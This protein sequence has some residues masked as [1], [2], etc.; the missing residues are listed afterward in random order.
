MN[1]RQ[2]RLEA[3]YAQLRQRFDGDPYLHIQ[4]LGPAP[5]ERYRITF[6]VPSLRLDASNQPVRVPVTVVDLTLPI[7]YPR[8]KPFAATIGTVFHPNFGDHICL[9]DYWSPAQSVA[10]I[11]SQIAEM[12]QWQRYNVRSPLNAI[13]AD[14]VRTHADQVPIGTITLGSPDLN[15]TVLPETGGAF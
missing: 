6:R 5:F 8:E 2:R 13:A 1:P 3:D 14:W 15:L 11:I 9:A 7:T 4:P 10:D 12:L